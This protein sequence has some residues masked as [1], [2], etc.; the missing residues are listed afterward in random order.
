MGVSLLDGALSWALIVLGLAAAVFLLARRERWWW[1]YVV[2]ATVV[3]SGVLGWIIGNT[4]ARSI[5]GE[6]LK[7]MDQVWIA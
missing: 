7:A 2:P 4:V 3:V 5:I 6:D 1:L